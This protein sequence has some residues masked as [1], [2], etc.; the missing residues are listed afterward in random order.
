MPDSPATTFDLAERFAHFSRVDCRGYSPMYEA[1]AAGVAEDAAA[2]AVIAAAPV[3][4]QHPTVVLAVL[5]DLALAGTAPEVAAAFA[6]GDGR[7][8][9]AAVRAAIVEHRDALLRAVGERQTQTN[10]VGRSALL[11][12]AVAEAAARVGAARVALVDVGCSAGL[13]LHLDRYAITYSDGVEVG[14]RSSP[15][16]LECE[17]V[18]ALAPPRPVPFPPVVDRVGIDLR[19]VDVRDP[20]EARWLQA[21]LWPDQPERIARLRGAF[22]VALEHPVRLVRG[23][24]IDVLPEVLA[25]LAPDALPVVTTTWAIAYLKPSDR[26]RFLQRLSAA[27]IDRPVAWV[28]AE[29]VGLA[30]AVPTLGDAKGSVHSLIGVAVAQGARFDVE[31]IARCHPHGRWVEWLKP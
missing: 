1:V 19:P 26:L 12:P 6:A 28:S 29:G 3:D 21:C 9:A 15:V 24:V 17:V 25:A 16:Q 18:G 31:T 4:K 27:A 22:A 10:E 7:A 14:E 8:A 5:H 11:Y 23:N 20:A 30:P 2:L 13:N